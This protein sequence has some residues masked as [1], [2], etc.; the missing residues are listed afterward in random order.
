MISAA[1]TT[2]GASSFNARPTRI[3][4]RRSGVASTRSYEPTVISNSRF[5]PV[6]PVPKRQIITMTPG[7]NHCSGDAPSSTAGST[8]PAS[9]GPNSPRKTSGCTNEKMI[10]N[11]SR[12]TS[13]ISRRNTAQMS[14]TR[15]LRWVRATG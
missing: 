9:N 13:E 8:E 12:S 10:E 4:E 2:S 15:E 14:A 5:D 1:W 7:R 6:M 11:G 3:D